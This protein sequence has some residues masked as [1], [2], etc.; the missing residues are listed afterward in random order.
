MFHRKG[1][2][3][4]SFETLRLDL[5]LMSA[6]AESG[7][8]SS[9]FRP[10]Q[11]V[12][13]CRLAVSVFS[14]VWWPPARFQETELLL[15]H[16]HQRQSLHLSTLRCC[17]SRNWSKFGVLKRDKKKHIWTFALH[18]RTATAPHKQPLPATLMHSPDGLCEGVG[19]A[20]QQA[21]AAR[22]DSRGCIRELDII[23]WKKQFNQFTP[24]PPSTQPNPTT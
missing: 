13:L 5:R 4:P 12:V 23:S 9:A 11:V 19:C 6:L 7:C 14:P 22:N 10:Q 16:H 3:H 18:L 15:E 2:F 1:A 21:W 17:R 20:R 24:N 8:T